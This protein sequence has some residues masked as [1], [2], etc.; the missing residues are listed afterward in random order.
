MHTK[1]RWPY[2][3]EYEC[4]ACGRNFTCKEALQEHENNCKDAEAL[5]YQSPR[6]EREFYE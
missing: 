2:E 5:L 1:A 4:I 6:Q 3:I